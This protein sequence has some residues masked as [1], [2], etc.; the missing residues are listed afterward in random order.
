MLQYVY[1]QIS[2]SNLNALTWPCS[3]CYLRKRRNT[4]RR[5]RSRRGRSWISVVYINIIMYS[6]N[7]FSHKQN[8][9]LICQHWALFDISGDC[10]PILGFHE[11]IL[12]LIWVAVNP[13]CIDDYAVCILEWKNRTKLHIF[14]AKHKVNT[15]SEK[16]FP[17][18]DCASIWSWPP[19]K[20]GR[21]VK[22]KNT[23]VSQRGEVKNMAAA[24][25]HQAIKA[26]VI[27][28]NEAAKSNILTWYHWAMYIN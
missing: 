26:L 23:F 9:S 3:G 19:V 7:S 2:I 21:H 15:Y 1:Q 17:S 13:K 11:G 25:R 27:Y 10:S 18:D 8:S 28:S 22:P 24:W 20:L 12:Q 6:S 16:L 4:T 5:R 14:A